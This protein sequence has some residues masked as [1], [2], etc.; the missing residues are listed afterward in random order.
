MPQSTQTVVS[1]FMLLADAVSQSTMAWLDYES[2]EAKFVLAS[3]KTVVYD[4]VDAC[5]I[6]NHL[7]DNCGWQGGGNS[8]GRK[9]VCKGGRFA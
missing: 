3:G 8:Y 2:N 5:G 4:N 9:L 7:I 1:T 6:L